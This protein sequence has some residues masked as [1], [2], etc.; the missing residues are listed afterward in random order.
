DE[1]AHELLVV[2]E[3]LQDALD[4]QVLLEAGR[5]IGLGAVHLRHPSH[6][7]ALEQR[8]LAELSRRRWLGSA[9]HG[10]GRGPVAAT[11]AAGSVCRS[12]GQTQRT[13]R[14]VSW[15]GD[16][17]MRTGDEAVVLPAGAERVR[18]GQPW[19]LRDQVLSAPRA[20]D[21]VRVADKRGN[22]LGTALW[23]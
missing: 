22:L 6:G 9:G 14:R 20:G 17:L 3:A 11:G 23:S 2:G 19:V 7:D 21:V 13:R 18:S 4:H 1:H 15:T 5:A 8:V 12:A 16:R 10:C